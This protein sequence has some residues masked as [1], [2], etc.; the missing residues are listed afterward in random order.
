MRR[1]GGRGCGIIARGDVEMKL[2]LIV[3]HCSHIKERYKSRVCLI[4]ST[5]FPWAIS[6]VGSIRGA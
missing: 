5:E 4:H 6:G 1:I 2:I 3:Q